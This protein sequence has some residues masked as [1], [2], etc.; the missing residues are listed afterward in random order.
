MCGRSGRVRPRPCRL[1]L[2]LARARREPCCAHEAWSVLAG[3]GLTLRPATASTK[4]SASTSAWAAPLLAAG[5]ETSVQGALCACGLS[6]RS[7]APPPPRSPS[8]ARVARAGLRSEWSRGL[9]APCVREEVPLS[10]VAWAASPSPRR[11]RVRAIDQRCAAL[12]RR[13]ARESARDTAEPCGIG[14]ALFLAQGEDEG[15]RPPRRSASRCPAAP[16]RASVRTMKP[17]HVA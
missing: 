11:V 6:D 4:C 3:F 7:P 13:L 10:C 9:V 14:C 1:A 17:S 12:Q 2:P 5:R 16:P 8:C 15:D